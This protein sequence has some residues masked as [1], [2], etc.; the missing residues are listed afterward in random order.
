MFSFVLQTLIKL[1][2]IVGR[3]VIAMAVDTHSVVK[4]FNIFKYESV[5]LIEVVDPE[6]V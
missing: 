4:G 6:A 3:H 5:S 2:I 1:L